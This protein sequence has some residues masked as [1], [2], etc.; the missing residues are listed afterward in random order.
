VWRLVGVEDGLPSVVVSYLIYVDDSG[1]EEI[2]DLFSALIIPGRRWSEML[3]YW[4]K[5]REELERS[6]GLPPKF[7]LHARSFL[8]YR[9]TKELTK[10]EQ[11][12]QRIFESRHADPALHAVALARA[13]IEL[14]DLTLTASL[15]AARDAGRSDRDIASVAR[16]PE[17]D[18]RDRLGGGTDVRRLRELDC[19]AENPTGRDA[20]ARMFER[21]VDQLA[22]LPDLEIVTVYTPVRTGPTKAALYGDL[23]TLINDW[24]AE[25]D[26]VGTVVVDG[27]P[28]ARTLYYREAHRKLE[29]ATRRILEDEILRDSR[30]SHF[31]QMADIA[32]YCAYQALRGRPDWYLRLSSAI[33]GPR[34]VPPSAEDLGV[35]EFAYASPEK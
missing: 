22:R 24:L 13:Q 35:R 20:R 7:E 15:R 30:E 26:A 27:T 4:R 34:D 25:R 29:L 16:M 17:S 19:M 8:S 31:I 1:D 11:R 28:S 21:C 14:G 2:G 10:E 23:L 6:N 18:V 9:P 12:R 5:L 3:T 32:A 33:R